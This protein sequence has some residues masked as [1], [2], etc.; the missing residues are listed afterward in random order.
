MRGWTG[1]QEF[2]AA[3]RPPFRVFNAGNR[4]NTTLRRK[5]LP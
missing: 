5:T 2:I 1:T 3:A 4:P